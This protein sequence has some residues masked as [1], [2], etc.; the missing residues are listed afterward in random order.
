MSFYPIPKPEFEDFLNKYYYTPFPPDLY[1]FDYIFNERTQKYEP[2]EGDINEYCYV[3][4]L[5]PE[6]GIKVYSGINRVTDASRPWG[7][8][9]IRLVPARLTT[10]EPI[11]P[12]FAHIKRL[13]TWKKN[14]EIRMTKIADSL[15]NNV[16]CPEC[17]EELRV[18]FARE[19]MKYFLG[20]SN[21]PSC[22]GNRELKV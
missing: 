7:E 12:P 10:L 19:K 5:S 2:K 4:M 1:H 20:C 18:R 17:H 22:K 21:Y 15:G 11:R 16:R 14:F 3:I 8:D 9:A 6:V 13:T